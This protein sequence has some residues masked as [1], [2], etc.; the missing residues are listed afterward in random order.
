MANQPI[1]IRKASAG[2]G[3]T[4]QLA[5]QYIINLL[6]KRDDTGKL[7]L[8][9]NPREA[10]SRILAITFTNKATNEM[11]ERIIK[12][13]ARLAYV[14]ANGQYV[15][16]DHRDAIR[17]ELNCTEAELQKAAAIAL[18]SLLF[19]YH[20]FNVSTIDSFFQL[21]LRTF[22]R[23]VDRPGDYRV[24]ID[25]KEAINAA[26][27]LMLDRA[28]QA[29][30][31]SNPNKKEDKAL[32]GLITRFM[33]SN[34]EKGN[35]FN[36]F[37]RNSSDLGNII[38]AI[39]N[40]L[41]EDFK[42][43]EKI[44]NYL[45]DPEKLPKFAKAVN[46]SAD[47]AKQRIVDL[48]KDFRKKFGQYDGNGANGKITP[49]FVK[50]ANGN[51]DKLKNKAIKETLLKDG[52]KYFN[53]GFVDNNS[54]DNIYRDIESYCKLLMATYADYMTVSAI[55]SNIVNLEF[56]QAVLT[57]IEQY[58]NDNNL[59]LLSDTT[60]ILHGLI[61][62]SDVPFIYEKLGT[63]LEDF[64]L[65]EFQ[66]TSRLQ[67][68]NLNPLIGNSVAGGG[69]NLIIG[70]EKQSI[71]RFRNADYKLLYKG[72]QDDFKDATDVIDGSN[73]ENNTNWRS[74]R[75]IIEFNNAFFSAYANSYA[76]SSAAIISDIYK[77][78]K[79][80]VPAQKKDGSRGLVMMRNILKDENG[81]ELNAE[82]FRQESLKRLIDDLRK[83]R[84]YEYNWGDIAI[85][86]DKRKE[87]DMVIEYLMKYRQDH[88]EE[89]LLDDLTVVSEESL[90]ISRADSVR[91]AVSVLRMLDPTSIENEKSTKEFSSAEI[92][93]RYEYMLLQARDKG[94]KDYDKILSDCLNDNNNDWSAAM[95]RNAYGNGQCTSLVTT[96][97][98]IISDN[99]PES[100]REAEYVYIQ[101]FIDAVIDLSARG[102][103]SIHSFLAWWDERGRDTGIELPSGDGINALTVMTIHKSK[104]LEFPCV[105]I[106]FAT[107]EMKK[108][109]DISWF[110]SNEAISTLTAA[111]IVADNIPPMLPLKNGS[112]LSNTCFAA[113]FNE[114]EA[115]AQLDT[116]NK[117]YVAF[118]RAISRLI[119]TFSCFDT[120]KFTK[121]G[122][123]IL[124][125]VGEFSKKIFEIAK[126][127]PNDNDQLVIGHEH[128]DYYGDINSKHVKEEKESDQFDMKPLSDEDAKACCID[129]YE[130]IKVDSTWQLLSSDD[131]LPNPEAAKDKGR[132]LHAVMKAIR[133][134][135]DLNRLETIIHR[136]TFR[137]CLTDKEI[138]DYADQLR[139][140]ISQQK[141]ERW[142]V[143]YSRLIAE[144]AIALFETKTRR[145]GTTYT[146]LTRRPD[147]VVVLPDGTVEIIDYKFGE[148]NDEH[149]SKQVQR[150]MKHFREMGYESVKGY[151]WYVL[152]QSGNNILEVK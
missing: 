49:E 73:P 102:I 38:G 95:A 16:S 55:S 90:L 85:L 87:G 43:S 62:D 70:D 45:K 93:C 31:D 109:S 29:L 106:P 133:T 5:R 105:I 79:Q 7:V 114:N 64:L 115:A 26:V 14:D 50:L 149:Y 30:D 139:N 60:D 104:G 81:G 27:Q 1:Q 136:R 107:W 69:S 65:D 17:N 10:H 142:F 72:V 9:D 74:V 23:E 147:R 25:D 146:V 46:D 122:K 91:F 68:E 143:G 152:E 98:Q 120:G 144:R 111:G 138:K 13:L 131:D 76:N 58:R 41:N 129:K 63:K 125:T 57:D 6:S 82:E 40:L 137:L 37:N 48:A 19:S 116:I 36:I 51:I 110:D 121:E 47:K 21:V 140:A 113:Q 20:N 34:V 59:I 3:K 61:K 119:I 117:A 101:A 97:E 103:T 11:K 42:R 92:A 18:R 35:K 22:A 148:R 150:Y 66:D 32:V 118:T 151:V 33:E 4:F 54:D 52:S 44:Q 124:Q 126:N 77:H 128:I 145:D 96:V 24:E 2:S 84:N 89:K 94:S 132:I 123:P 88:P 83:C 134:K 28:K 8:N 78:V 135:A 15:K 80:N 141:V 75:D 53:K 130:A 86:V 39:S 99:V 127:L 12:E 100:I 108:N 67:W 56:L 112:C 71:Y